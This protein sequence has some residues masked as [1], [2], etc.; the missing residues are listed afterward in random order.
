MLSEVGYYLAPGALRGI[1]DEECPRLSGELLLQNKRLEPRKLKDLHRRL[2]ESLL[3]DRGRPR[4]I[5]SMPDVSP[6]SGVFAAR[7]TGNRRIGRV[8]ADQ[9]D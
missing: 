8:M 2:R 1:L 5:G 7:T 9:A 3:H 4:S 6:K